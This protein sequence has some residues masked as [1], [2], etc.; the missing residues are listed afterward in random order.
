MAMRSKTPPSQRTP[1]CS[2]KS[3]VER[4][5]GTSRHETFTIARSANCGSDVPQLVSPADAA[6]N[7]ASPLRFDWDPVSGAVG[8]AVLIRHDGGAQTVL[9]ETASTSLTRRLPEGNFEW[10]VVA[11]FAGCPPANSQHAT[12]TI[13]VTSCSNRQPI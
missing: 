1:A 2:R 13:P 11:F 7:V 3:A 6:T 10:W 5:S 8:Y 9:A 4:S 12:F